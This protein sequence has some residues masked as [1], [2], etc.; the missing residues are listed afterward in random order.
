EVRARW[1]R[2]WQGWPQARS[3]EL[4][5]TLRDLELIIELGAYRARVRPVLH[6]EAPDLRRVARRPPLD[7]GM[8]GAQGRHAG[9]ALTVGAAVVHPKLVDA[10]ALPGRVELGVDLDEDPVSGLRRERQRS[11]G[12]VHPPVVDLPEDVA[13]VLNA[14]AENPILGGNA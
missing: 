4:D 7:V 14:G 6:P 1:G 12:L 8:L 13:L 2:R 11:A 3:D 5:G 9:A 10:V